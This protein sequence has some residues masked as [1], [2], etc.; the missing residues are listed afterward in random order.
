M[1]NISVYIRIRIDRLHPKRAIGPPPGIK[2]TREQL[3]LGS[4]QTTIEFR[5]EANP[6]SLSPN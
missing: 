3:N 2:N 5:L 6:I 1:V 4:D